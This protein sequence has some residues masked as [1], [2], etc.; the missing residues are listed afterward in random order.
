MV[1]LLSIFC[2]IE[3]VLS[4]LVVCAWLDLP[5]RMAT[6]REL[7][8]CD[9]YCNFYFKSLHI[10]SETPPP[11]KKNNKITRNLSLRESWPIQKSVSVT[12]LEGN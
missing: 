2:I 4:S 1:A 10:V 5:L 12:L 7:A 8:F 9:P 3:L 11:Q 6:T